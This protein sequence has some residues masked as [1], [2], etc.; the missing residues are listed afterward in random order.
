[1]FEIL[2]NIIVISLSISLTAYIG[3]TLKEKLY[4]KNNMIVI[5]KKS[6]TQNHLNEA[7]IKEF[8]LKGQKAKSG[9]EVRILTKD[10]EKYTGILI[11]GK[12]KDSEI[13]IVT[14]EDEIKKV[15]VENIEKFN[16][17]IKYGKFFT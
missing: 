10:R 4:L 7:D 11:G 8:I 12:R 1:M 15:K 14:R 6:V 3:L 9:D 16:V 5:E 13:L 17:L 2:Q